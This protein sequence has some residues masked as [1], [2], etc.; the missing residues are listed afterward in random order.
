MRH[1]VI[2]RRALLMVVAA[3]TLASADAPFLL[4]TEEEAVAGRVGTPAPVT[5]SVAVGMPRIEIDTPEGSRPQ[6]VPISFR[7]RFIP[8]PDAAIDPNS[9]RAFYGA[10]GI[11]I[12][13]RL[14]GR[15]RIDAAG[16]VAENVA[17]PSGD[18]RVVLTITDSRGRTGRR[19]HRFTVN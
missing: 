1:L 14:R 12:T 3:P 6:S 11:D 19:E 8:G 2:A 17:V 16:I 4:V 5:R 18:H 7:L 15:A 9:F 13:D 10:F